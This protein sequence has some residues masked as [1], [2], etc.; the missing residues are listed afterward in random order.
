MEGSMRFALMTEP[1]QGISYEE[2]LAIARAAE[3]AGFEAY[4]RSDHYTSFPGATGLHTTDAWAT[5]AGLARETK[6]IQ[7]GTLVSPVTFRIPG[8]LAKV[9]AT[10]DEMSGGRVEVG[11]G[12]GWNDL[13]HAQLGL[14][15]PDTKTR[16]DQMEEEL[17][18]LRGL[19]DEPD[20]WSF[21][22]QHWQV[23]G[24]L[25]RPRYDESTPRADG[26]R[27]P[28]IIVGGS[29]KPRSLRIAAKYADEYNASGA[30][31]EEV[32][33]IV[34]DLDAACRAIGRDPK[35]I[36][37]SIMTGVLIGRDKAGVA[38]RVQAQ[39]DFFGEGDG[40]G[41]LAERQGR[42]VTGTFAEARATIQRFVD[43][44][45]ERIMLQDFLPR[46]LEHVALMGE[47][48]AG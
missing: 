26:R 29:G 46:D 4:F 32:A 24:S 27:R 6:R 33:V 17:I 47:L 43:A 37:R 7:I 11:V 28:N 1:Q 21:E 2:I 36:T 9:A 22:G 40:P 30:S 8:E 15:Y 3:A 44:G 16:I 18:I 10:V 20:G 48:I 31:P 41:W 19:W 5:L 38:A 35:T 12:G 34:R 42:W 13:E 23:R 25:F 14:P 45:A 39:L